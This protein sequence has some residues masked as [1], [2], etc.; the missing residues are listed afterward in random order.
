MR[1][2]IGSS[3]KGVAHAV[4]LV[5]GVVAGLCVARTDVHAQQAAPSCPGTECAHDSTVHL[6]FPGP[7]PWRSVPLSRWRSRKTPSSRSRRAA[8]PAVASRCISPI[9]SQPALE[10][11][12]W[13]FEKARGSRDRT[14]FGSRPLPA[15]RTGDEGYE[16]TITHRPAPASRRR[17]RRVCSTGFRRC[18]SCC[19]GRSNTAARGPSTCA[20]RPR[21]SPTSR[22]L[23]GAARSSTSRGTSSRQTRSSATSISSRCTSSTASTCTSP[24]IRAGASRSR[25]GRT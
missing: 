1:M 7:P 12:L 15:P 16:L 17:P 9:W 10:A 24:T 8:R 4:A 25:R 19:R 20:C 21:T 6:S 13:R 22:A 11:S 3:R 18:G 2:R 14:S 5:A 23:A